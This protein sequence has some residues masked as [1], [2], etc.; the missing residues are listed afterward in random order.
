M[1]ILI[2]LQALIFYLNAEIVTSSDILIK[3]D[4][5]NEAVSLKAGTEAFIKDTRI[6]MWYHLNDKGLEGFIEPECIGTKGTDLVL[7][8]ACPVYPEASSSLK[9]LTTAKT[10]IVLKNF[11]IHNEVEH[12]VV[13]NGK[14]FWL[15]SSVLRFVHQGLDD[16]ELYEPVSIQEIIHLKKEN[17]IISPYIDKTMYVSTLLGVF[18]SVDAKKWYRIKKLEPQKYEIALTPDGWLV[19]DNLFSKDQGRSFGEFFPAYAF[20]YKDTY[21]KSVMVSPQGNNSIYITFATSTDP[22]NITLF[23]L[24]KIEDGWKRIYPTADGKVFTVPVEDTVTSILGFINNKWLRVNK[25]TKNK[26]VDLDDI[27]V[28]GTGNKRTV[29]ILLRSFEKTAVKDYQVLLSLDYTVGSGWKVREEK[30]RF[31]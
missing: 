20:P 5:S 14:P 10:G 19:A 7:L 25:N 15:S 30:W 3:G 18:M 13:I 1:F 27:S 8:K 31:I 22:S 6:S 12:N 11:K 9:P 23:V 29:S 26:K 16:T 21:V 2:F 4:G 28:S 24:G 17:P